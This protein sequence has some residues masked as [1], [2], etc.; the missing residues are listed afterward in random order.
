MPE[1]RKEPPARHCIECGA[2]D[3]HNHPCDSEAE[4]ALDEDADAYFDRCRKGY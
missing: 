4:L 3:G 2:V 1:A